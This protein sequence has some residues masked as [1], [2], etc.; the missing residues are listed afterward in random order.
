VKSAAVVDAGAAQPVQLEE[1]RLAARH[2]TVAFGGEA[3]HPVVN[4]RRRGRVVD[5]DVRRGRKAGIDCYAHQAAFPLGAHGHVEERL[6]LQR[7]V[8]DDPQPALLLADE[9]AAVWSQGHGRRAGEAVGDLDR[10]E[11]GR[12]ADRAQ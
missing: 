5:V 4:V 10:G 11:A 6:G 2:R 8:L 7:A 3:A 1:D 12:Q 9:D